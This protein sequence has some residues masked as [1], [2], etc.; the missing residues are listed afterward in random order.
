MKARE[1]ISKYFS[2]VVQVSGVGKN[3]AGRLE[4]ALNDAGFVI[5][6]KE[7]TEGM[8]ENAPHGRIE[9]LE[10][11]CGEL[12]QVIGTLANAHG[13]LFDHPA[14]IKALDNA[15]GAKFIHED[16]LPFIVPLEVT[17]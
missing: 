11:L 12:Y 1:V 10:T 15:S 3:F 16:V 6:P 17:S 5:L 14:V 7:P 9:E 13:D 4:R 2:E 8:I